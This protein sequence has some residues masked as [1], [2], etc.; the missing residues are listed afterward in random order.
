MR[1]FVIIGASRGLGAAFSRGLPEPGD[2]VWLVSR[3]RPELAV[4]DGAQRQWI[5][6][7]L[8]DRAAAG[9][10]AAAL[11]GAPVEVLVYNAGIWEEA[12][13][14]AD[15]DF[16]QVPAEENERIL[17]VNL[18]AALAVVQALL[19]NL[20]QAAA[21]KIILI[22]STSGLENSRAPEVAYNASKF[23]L[24]GAAQG[25]REHLRRDGIAVT[26]VNPGSLAT[27][28]PWEAGAAPVLRRHGRAALPVGDVAA[29]VKC[30]INL[31]PAAC[32]KEI[33]LPAMDDMAA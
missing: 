20:R 6:A 26:V 1:R 4:A 12:A 18:S 7:D 29:L 25:L 24:R 9:R 10:I 5:P 33:D 23:G 8:T 31:S 30:L 13:F 2:Q 14:G 17:T 27:D 28:V 15:Y 11:A 21:A 19:P 16:A 32:V 22:G 3:G